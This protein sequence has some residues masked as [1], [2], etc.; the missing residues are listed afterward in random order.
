VKL[1]KAEESDRIDGT[2]N[3]EEEA[4]FRVP[5]ATPD[6]RRTLKLPC[7]VLTQDEL[8]PRDLKGAQ[9]A[10]S[11]Y[12]S[13]E[14]GQELS[15]KPM[16]EYER[17]K[18]QT[19]LPPGAVTDLIDT[20]LMDNDFQTNFEWNYDDDMSVPSSYA[21][22]VA[23][24]FTSESLASSASTLSRG[25]GFSA[26]QIATAT[27]ELLA[28]VIEVLLSLYKGALDDP[29]IGPERLER[30][31]RRLFRQIPATNTIKTLLTS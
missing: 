22:S 29:S 30:N 4:A 14:D 28:V 18:Q 25:S 3:R 19:W 20:R 27:K 10:Q 21:A 9:E 6:G 15:A 8:E 26:V 13:H 7:L 2:H 17:F 16:Q 23:S 12:S 1:D 11:K 24:I 31:L 5:Q